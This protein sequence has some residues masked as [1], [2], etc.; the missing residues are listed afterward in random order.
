MNSSTSFFGVEGFMPHGMCFVWRADLLAVHVIS[1][2]LI[3]ASYFAIPVA[4][5]A[6]LR[7]RPSFNYRGLPQLFAAFIVTCGATH[8]LS[9]VV[10]WIPFYGLE[11][12]AKLMTALASVTTAFVL[13]R[14]VPRI[15]ELPAPSD[16]AERNATILRLNAQL[17]ER[18]HAMGRLAGGIA[19]DFNNFM[20]LVRGNLEQLVR[21]NLELLRLSIDSDER[22]EILDELDR[23]SERGS[24]LAA[25]ML[26]VSGTGSLAERSA[27]LEEIADRVAA[28]EGVRFQARG[29]PAVVKAAEDQV[30]LALRELVHNAVEAAGISKVNVYV[31]RADPNRSGT[32]L[33][34]FLGRPDD[35]FE[36]VVFDRGPG[37]PERLGDSITAPYSTSKESGRGL[38]LSVV[39]GVCAS[40]EGALST[41]RDRSGTRFLLAF[42]AEP[43]VEARASSLRA[44]DSGQEGGPA[45]A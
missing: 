5:L 41:L 1:D 39:A 44:M 26:A 32:V 29:Q 33:A 34:D 25:R 13:W 11:G 7:R 24:L 30:E 38:G 2:L 27:D 8:L 22:S 42:R 18:V 45:V 16:V 23:A 12:I 15:A 6:I 28:A 37:V 10:I 19:H 31:R 21:G 4:L 9:L 20:Q 3:A 35:A 43:S 40:Q 36:L 14:L 17:G